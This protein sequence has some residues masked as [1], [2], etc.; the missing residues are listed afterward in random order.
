MGL[1]ILVL[2]L[3]MIL[4]PEYTWSM[5]QDEAHYY[6]GLYLFLGVGLFT[7]IVAFVGCS[8]AF[9][10]SQCML[11]TVSVFQNQIIQNLINLIFFSSSVVCW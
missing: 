11:V 7:I 6:Y 8:G 3:F 1:A 4:D 10:E 2:S 5:T 9:K